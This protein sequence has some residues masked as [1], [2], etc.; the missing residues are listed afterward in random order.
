MYSIRRVIP[1]VA[2]ISVVALLAAGCGG[3]SPT[4][5]TTGSAAGNSSPNDV[6]GSAYRYSACMRNHGATNF[7]D[8]KVH[9]S[10]NGGSTQVAVM[11]PAG[12]VNSPQVKAAQTACKGILPAPSKSDL[13]QEAHDQL[14]HKEDL[15]SFTRCIRQHGINGFPDPN[16]QGQMSLQEIQAAGID[17]TAPNVK[18]AALAC[19]PASNG[20]VT[21]AAVLQA[22]S[23]NVPPSGGTGSESSGAGSNP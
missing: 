6:A 13:A 12:A 14:V 9:I 1:V 11:I 19:V 23:G 21:R 5:T 17:L 8:P 15:L 22:T 10:S 4:T 18:A 2:A 7:P 3:V 20:G 16:S